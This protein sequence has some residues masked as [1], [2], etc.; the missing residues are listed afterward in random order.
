MMK[1]SERW[2]SRDGEAHARRTSI[3]D[4]V[5]AAAVPGWSELVVRRAQ[6]GSYAVTSV[7]RDGREIAVEAVD[8]PF[9]LL[10]EVSY[11]PGVGT[12]FTCELAFAPHGRGYTG[13]VD[14]SAPP[15]ADV[16]PAAALAELTTFPREDTPGWLL[17]AL[18]TTVPLTAPTTYGDH[19][20]RWREHRGRH[21]LP[22][23]DGDLV[24]VPAAVMTAR[25]FDHGVERGQHLWHV[26]EKDAAGADALMISAYEQKYWV[27]RDGARGIGEGV[28]S[29]SLD[30]AVL[31]LELTSEAAD[32]L[33]TE[34][35]YEV[36]LDL[37]PESIDRLRAAVPDMFRLV[38]DAPELIGF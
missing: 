18:P 15:L 6:V 1:R 19:Y 33:R 3:G 7:I 4:V 30:G 23:I 11:R 37:P 2:R 20:D 16:P 14:A 5:R 34:T 21:P 10:R 38:D 13:R 35:L 9:R 24:Y 12:W 29:L 31:R 28:R 32:E 25:V 27:G 22:P 17:D 36:R 26:A 8:E